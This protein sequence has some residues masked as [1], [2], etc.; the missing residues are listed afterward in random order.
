MYVICCWI[1]YLYDSTSLQEY[2]RALGDSAEKVSIANQLY[3][4]VGLCEHLFELSFLELSY[5]YIC[6]CN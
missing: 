4:M 6:T 1:F 3:D 2:E 5:V